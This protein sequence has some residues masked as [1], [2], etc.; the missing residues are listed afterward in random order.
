VT[1]ARL[2]ATLGGAGLLRPGPGTWGS[3]VVL[4][5]VLLGPLACLALAALIAAAGFWAAPRV[6]TAEAEDPGWFVADEGAGMLVALAALPAP[7]LI[8]VALAFALFRALDIAKPWP[9]SWADAQPGAFGVMADDI[10]AGVIAALAL[11]ALHAI[12]PGV[13]A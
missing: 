11:L 8:G 6:L 13:L 3:A 7:T 5:L 4:P 1:A 2:V 12:H 10:L 9:V